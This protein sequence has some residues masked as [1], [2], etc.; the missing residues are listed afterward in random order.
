MSATAEVLSPK[1]L[2]KLEREIAET[3]PPRV[4]RP[5]ATIPMPEYVDH[6]EGV[7]R[8]GALSAEAVV[9][10]FEATAKEIE[11]MGAELIDAARKCESMTADVHKA[12]AL[13]QE[14]AAAYREE[15]KTIF[16]RIEDC[17]IITE[18]VR[19]TCA[20]L[21]EKIAGDLARD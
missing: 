1:P 2:V 3:I 10:D 17:S 18:N 21:R 11:A 19:T 13:V 7:S 4:M 12:I 6:Q 14:T 8:V 16:K 20:A 5:S 15:A 9:R